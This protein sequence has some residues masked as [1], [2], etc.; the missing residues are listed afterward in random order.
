V[1]IIPGFM[2]NYGYGMMG[3]GGMFFGLL[4][5]II[6]IVL[7][8][9]LIK[10]LVEQNKTRSGEGKSALDIAKERYAKGEI[11]KEEFEEIKGRLV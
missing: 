3:S 4:F 7:A 1:V 10:W 9:F 2:D 6:I 11:T 5:W 8:Y